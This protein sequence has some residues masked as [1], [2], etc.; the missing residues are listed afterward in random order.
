MAGETTV[1]YEGRS[2]I[3]SRPLVVGDWV[4]VITTSDRYVEVEVI[5]KGFK[6]V[7]LKSV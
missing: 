1:P 5:A 2:S 4:V 6:K 7:C 3:S